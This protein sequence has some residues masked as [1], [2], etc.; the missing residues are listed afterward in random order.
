M[1]KPSSVTEPVEPRAAS[2]RPHPLFILPPFTLPRRSGLTLLVLADGNRRSSPGGGYAGGACRVVSIAEHLAGRPDVA[3]MVACILSPDNVVKRGDGCFFE[4][5]K[6][7]FELGVA[8]ET[9][10]ALVGA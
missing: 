3:V 6:A 5:Y 10:G 4:L 2:L 7:F 8:I 9:R 1:D